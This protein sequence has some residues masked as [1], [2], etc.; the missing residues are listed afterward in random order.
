MS[1]KQFYL[2]YFLYA[3]LSLCVQDKR[4]RAYHHP[5]DRMIHYQYGRYQMAPGKKTAYAP[6][7]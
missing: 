3:Y 4:N 1:T 5:D 6:W 7:S 2:Y